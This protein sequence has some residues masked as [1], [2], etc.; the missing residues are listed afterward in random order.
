MLNLSVVRGPLPTQQMEEILR[1][2][3]RLT[4][5]QIA[6]AVFRRWVQEGPEGPAFHALLTSN[7]RVVGHFCLMRLEAEYCGKPLAVA[8]AEYFFVHE[9]F[10]SEKVRGHEDS[11]LSPAILLLD[12]LYSHCHSIG[13]GPFIASSADDIRPFHELVGCR[14]LDVRLYEC[15]LALRPLQ[16]AVH[17][18]NLGRP[19]RAALFASSL[20]QA[21]LWRGARLIPRR[22]SIQPIP[23]EQLSTLS[24]THSIAFFQKP[25]SLSWRYPH[26]EYLVIADELD[27][28]NYLIAKKGS[29]ER[30]LR[31]CQWC[32]STPDV[33][34]RFARALF[35]HAQENGMMGVRWAVFDN[36][37]QAAALVRSL[38]RLAFLC[39][40]RVRP[41]LVYSQDD[42]F[43][44]PAIWRIS[45]FLFCFEL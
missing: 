2:F 39:V 4:H 9:D 27:P 14:P 11:F 26:D 32:F 5:S 16:A 43:L 20:A 34:P 28:S 10:R 45:D 15:L 7:E 21:T 36:E 35:C 38:R 17:T 41:L 25:A 42:A 6:F 8:R 31:V 24:N 40:P 12:Q 18:P 44:E 29:P 3:N 23:I 22:Q 1:E 13:W 30:Y 19:Q 37:P 33:L